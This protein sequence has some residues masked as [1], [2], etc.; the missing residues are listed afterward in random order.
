MTF[1]VYNK[2]KISKEGE[3]EDR[4]KEHINYSKR[5]IKK[6]KSLY[7]IFSTAFTERYFNLLET[8]NTLK[9]THKLVMM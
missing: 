1:S 3:R 9:R 6:N 4:I 7:N 2:T 5:Y 8:K